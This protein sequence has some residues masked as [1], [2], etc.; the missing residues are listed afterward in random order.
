MDV[1]EEIRGFKWGVQSAAEHDETPQ[2]SVPY[3]WNTALRS[4]GGG[5][6]TL[7]TRPGLKIVNE[8]ALTGSP[9][10]HLMKN[11][12]YNNSGTIV[13]KFAI[14]TS[15]GRLYFKDQTNTIG[16]EIT[17]PAN[18]PYTSGRCFASGDF[19][20][21]ATVM[22]NRLFLVNSNGERRS[23]LNETFKMFGLGTLSSV[24]ITN[25][26][27][28]SSSMP[29]ET[30]D[31]VTTT[32][33]S[34]TGAESSST[35]VTSVTLG[36]NERIRVVITPTASESARYSHWRVYIRRQT[37]QSNLFRVL[38]LE[39]VGGTNIVADG[40]IPIA[41]TTVYVDLSATQISQ[42]ILVSPDQQENNEPPTSVKYITTFGGRL[43]CADGQNIY[44]SKLNLPDAFPTNNRESIITGEGDEI[45]GIREYSSDLCL[46][47]TTNN[48]WC[49]DGNDP[50]SW[51]IKPI[52]HSVGC[53][54][55]RSIVEMPGGTAW[56]SSTQGPVL[57]NGNSVEKIG[58]DKLGSPIVVDDV[59]GSRLNAIVSGFDPLE[60]RIL[61]SYSLLNTASR[62]DAIVPFSTRMTQFE[63]TRWNPMDF[64]AYGT[65]YDTDN[66]L[67]LFCGNYGG[68]IF[69]LDP[70]TLNDGVPSGTV[71]GTFVPSDASPTTIDGTGFYTTGAGLAERYIVVKNSSGQIVGR[72]RIASNTNTELTLA[73]A[74][75]V[76]AGE[77]HT[78][79]IGGADFR[80]YTKQLD[81]RQAFL[82]KRV[83]NVYVHIRTTNDSEELMVST[84]INYN[85]T[86][87]TLYR[88]WTNTGV[89]W[90]APDA[91]YDSSDWGGG[92]EAKKR[93]RIVRNCNAVQIGLF[94]STPNKDIII[95]KIAALARSLSDRYYG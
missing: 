7:G 14:V 79:D 17:P 80:L 90:D 75:S 85:P 50:Q 43:I 1:M 77:T 37:T 25:Q 44:Y 56:W 35:A 33:D 30:Y 42:H 23:V 54:G 76:T 91:I 66:K 70:D 64:S 32:Y 9:S 26:S 63:A 13:N 12:P 4:I 24:A 93:F 8:S 47:F 65:G 41:T 62:N 73:N 28:G 58:L 55:H 27:G 57:F 6:A 67:K 71:S 36:A 15:T 88:G 87:G 18:F 89:T 11:Y 53:A 39:N 92:A 59:E 84:L 45:K 49:I 21:D 95:L 46:I 19:P 20:V 94:H 72:E 2:D 40:N 3:A 83:D 82:R 61:M 16:S 81:F 48:I 86:V 74:I 29:A 31:V 51:T 52:D 22:G 38:T 60:Q 78:Y 10:F 69:I 68:Q 5:T 34:A